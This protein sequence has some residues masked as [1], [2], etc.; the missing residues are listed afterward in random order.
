[1]CMHMSRVPLSSACTWD[2]FGPRQEPLNSSGACE[3]ASAKCELIDTRRPMAC[4][5]QYVRSFR[6]FSLRKQCSAADLA[7]ALC[8]RITYPYY[9]SLSGACTWEYYG[10]HI[11]YP[12]IKYQAP[13]ARR[14]RLCT[15]HYVSVLCIKRR[16]PAGEGYLLR[17]TYPYYISSAESPPE[18]AIC[19]THYV[20]V[21]CIKRRKPA[22]ESYGVRITYPYYISSAEP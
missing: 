13:K 8:L 7:L 20:S 12:R 5:M 16:K 14:R 21:L 22:G 2:G 3:S 18:R 19:T 9:P 11:T 1:L 10:P 6:L 15:T 4:L 17:I